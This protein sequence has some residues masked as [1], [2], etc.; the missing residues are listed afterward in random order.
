MVPLSKTIWCT[1]LEGSLKFKDFHDVQ[2]QLIQL[3]V[4]VRRSLS[5][6]MASRASVYNII[7]H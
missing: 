4:D 1:N 6:P 5:I 2:S 3:M 7:S